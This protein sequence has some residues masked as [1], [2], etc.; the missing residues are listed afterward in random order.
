[1]L[2]RSALDVP[3]GD[4]VWPGTLAMP[5]LPMGLIVLV[6]LPAAEA[7]DR[8][9][10]SLFQRQGFA[11]LVLTVAG[12]SAS[13]AIVGERLARA[14]DVVVARDLGHG[15]PI[16]LCAGESA[17]AAA[18][19]A[20]AR[21]PGIV[22]AVTSLGGRI[23]APLEELACVRAP[24]LLV[25]GSSDL[26]LVR[27]AREAGRVLLAKHEVALISGARHQLDQP[28]VL[29]ETAV[30]CGRWFSRHFVADALRPRYAAP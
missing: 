13:E 23:D 28:G 21:R 6:G 4:A 26:A 10:A 24:T 3:A 1:M 27:S 8:E 20:A 16:G 5:A 19:I 7:R 14:L 18:M 29:E 2:Q 9:L 15:L 22:K 11:T 25:V 30:L 17:S 12:A